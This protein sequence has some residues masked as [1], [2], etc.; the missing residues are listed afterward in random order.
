MNFRSLPSSEPCHQANLKLRQ[1]AIASSW[2]LLSACGGGGTSGEGPPASTTPPDTGSVASSS[3]IPASCQTA[4][5]QDPAY[6]S[7]LQGTWT[8]TTA[9]GAACKLVW[10]GSAHPATYSYGVDTITFEAADFNWSLYQYAASTPETR[11][12]LVAANWQWGAGTGPK[13]R[14]EIR[15]VLNPNDNAIEVSV[16][17]RDAP[18]INSSCRLVR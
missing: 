3:F 18:D 12:M 6:L 17:N 5:S 9:S 11:I 16:D 1:L 7:C 2:V 15:W 4:T 10:N 13:N 8:G 14:G